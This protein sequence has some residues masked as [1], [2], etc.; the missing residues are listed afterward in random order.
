MVVCYVSA[1]KHLDNFYGLHPI[2]Q[3]TIILGMIILGIIGMLV[4][5]PIVAY[6]TITAF[7]PTPVAMILGFIYEFHRFI[8]VK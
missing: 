8:E 1:L 7:F 6:V 4:N 2:V 5:Q 3:V